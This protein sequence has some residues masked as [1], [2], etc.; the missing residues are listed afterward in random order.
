[1]ATATKLTRSESVY[2]AAVSP[3][4]VVLPLDLFIHLT[5][6]SPPR[7]IRC[8]N[9]VCIN[10]C[11]DNKSLANICIFALLPFFPP[12][13]NKV[14]ASVLNV[15]TLF[16]SSYNVSILVHLSVTCSQT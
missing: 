1:M 5:A 6:V 14:F 12:H 4:C 9:L 2:N 3:T 13:C 7:F 8:E 10:V 16:L 11:I 15:H